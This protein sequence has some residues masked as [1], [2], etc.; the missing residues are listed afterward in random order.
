MRPGG[1]RPQKHQLWQGGIPVAVHKY[2]PGFSGNVLHSDIQVLA[3]PLGREKVLPE[4]L[5]CGISR[6]ILIC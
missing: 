2:T 6:E 4:M 5:P 3:S 1:L